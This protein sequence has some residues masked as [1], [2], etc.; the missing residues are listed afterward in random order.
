MFGLE[1]ITWNTFFAFL[2]AGLLCYYIL[3][4]AHAYLKSSRQPKEPLFEK[5]AESGPQNKPFRTMA[6]KAADYPSEPITLNLHEK[7][8][9]LIDLKADNHPDSGYHL[10][11][12]Y[13]DTLPERKAFLEHVQYSRPPKPTTRKS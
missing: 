11:N 1:Q 10:E 12:L 3:L 7:D 4:M 8:A 5:E 2:L 9:L 13:Q 6:V